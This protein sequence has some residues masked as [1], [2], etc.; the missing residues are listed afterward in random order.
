MKTSPRIE[1]SFIVKKC[2]QVIGKYVKIDKIK[3]GMPLMGEAR[4]A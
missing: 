3:W 2:L 1:R 4:Q